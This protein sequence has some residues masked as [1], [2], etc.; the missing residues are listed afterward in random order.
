[1]TDDGMEALRRRVLAAT[2]RDVPAAEIAAYRER[3]QRMVA[4]AERL[5]VLEPELDLIEPATVNATLGGR[6]P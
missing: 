6:Q 2:G 4:F 1:M 5:A 3:F